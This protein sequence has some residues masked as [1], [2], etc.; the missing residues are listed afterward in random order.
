M[1]PQTADITGKWAKTGSSGCAERYPDRIEFR[2]NGIY[3]GQKDPPGTFTVWD[4]GTWRLSEGGEI[5]ISTANDAVVGYKISIS[6]DTLTFTD[7]EGCTIHYKNT[8]G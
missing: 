3:F 4:A 1:N 8:N 5:H 7:T 2:E 6:P